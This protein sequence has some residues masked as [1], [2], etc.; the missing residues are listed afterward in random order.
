MISYY[1]LQARRSFR[2]HGAFSL[3]E[4]LVAVSIIGLVAMM[5]LIS[6]SGLRSRARDNRR[7]TDVKVYAAALE[8]YRVLYGTYFLELSGTCNMTAGNA[9]CVGKDGQSWGRMNLKASIPGIPTASYVTAQT[10]A[11]LLRSKQLINTIAR[12]PRNLDLSDTV[13]QSRDYVLVRCDSSNN[14]VTDSKS[15]VRMAIWA[16]LETNTSLVEATNSS[17]RCGGS[18]SITSNFGTRVD[19]GYGTAAATFLPPLRVNPA[20]NSVEDTDEMTKD[21]FSEGSGSTK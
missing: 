9:Q 21:Y 10:M 16:D 8:N 5:G 19:F 13:G 4:L 18:L 6:F 1:P 11:E 12:D 14:Q 7:K 20:T 2:N 17:G 3:I 15:D